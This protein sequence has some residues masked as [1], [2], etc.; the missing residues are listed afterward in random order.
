M[1]NCIY[2]GVGSNFNLGHDTYNIK[3]L[4][5]ISVDDSFGLLMDTLSRL[6]EKKLTFDDKLLSQEI[7]EELDIEAHS[8]LHEWTVDRLIENK[9][10]PGSVRE[11]ILRLRTDIQITMTDKHSIEFYR[12]DPDWKRLR[13]EASAIIEEI[14]TATN[15]S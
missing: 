11:R 15:K 14:K 6:E 12:L 9:R 2:S 13:D 3:A 5:E 7:F 8:F 4:T 10:I 1:G